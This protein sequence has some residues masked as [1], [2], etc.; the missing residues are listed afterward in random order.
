MGKWKELKF[1]DS[2]E[3]QVIQEKLDELENEAVSYNPSRINLFAALDLTPFDSV[4]VVLLG[5][6][7]YPDRYMATGLAF[8]IPEEVY[9]EKWPPTLCNILTEYQDDLGYPPPR[10][11]NLSVWAKRGVLLLNA[12]P[13]CLTGQP[14]SHSNWTEWSYLTRE[15]I[16]TLDKEI[17][18][19]FI[20]LGKKAQEYDRFLSYSPSILTSHPSPLGARHG[21]LG[22]KIFSRANELLVKQGD[23]P[24]NWR[25]NDVKTP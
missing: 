21:F 15:I 25:L 22:S 6:D 7:P 17:H 20:F 16:E 9:T 2:G 4:R 18:P 24:I 10:N 23:A 19:I 11:G 3:W 12:T 13:T 5:Q 8:S 14:G 1:W